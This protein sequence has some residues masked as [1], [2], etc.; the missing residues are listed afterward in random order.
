MPE[1]PTTKLAE[2]QVINEIFLS[3]RVVDREA[4]NDFAGS[5]RKLIEQAAQ[6]LDQLRV[7]SNEAG[8]V[9]DALREVSGKTQ[10]RL[11]AA[12]R[13][14]ATI[15]ARAGDAERLLT[16]AREA[17]A[18][19]DS[20]KSE[21]QTTVQ[22]QLVTIELRLAGLHQRVEEKLVE[23][24][25]RAAEIADKY[26]AMLR[27][28][29]LELENKAV[30]QAQ[31]V[32][33]LGALL[34]R[35]ETLLASHGQGSLSELTNR[36]EQLA[37]RAEQAA[38]GVANSAR[39]G[40][41]LE[42]RIRRALDDGNAK[43]EELRRSLAALQSSTELALSQASAARGVIEQRQMELREALDEP[44]T[45]FANHADALEVRLT[46]TAATLEAAQQVAKQSAT[47][48]TVV[49]ERMSALLDELRPWKPVLIERRPGD[50]LPEPLRRILSEAKAELG[51]DIGQIAQ[52]MQSIFSRK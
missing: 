44:M 2:S 27:S 11:E 13:V 20:L 14:M 16:Q 9:R 23:A 50:E 17:S 4:Y 10:P 46:R 37:A 12:A 42:L 24:E 15:D 28:R 31:A 18:A 6:Q 32:S 45:D 21:S 40:E 48:A 51:Q 36:I 22:E 49:V 8:A 26:E 25:R 38:A 5:L 7:A 19:L 47:G 35:S 29:T 52:A 34:A 43:C 33:A 39:E 3:P 30:A 1:A 41:A